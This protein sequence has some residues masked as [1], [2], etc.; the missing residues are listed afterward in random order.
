MSHLVLQTLYV[1]VVCWQSCF[2]L[3]MRTWKAGKSLYV[4]SKEHFICVSLTLTR[5]YRTIA[6][7]TNV[8]RKCVIGVSSSRHTSPLVIGCINTDSF[9]TDMYT[10]QIQ[11]YKYNL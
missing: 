1:G 9:I 4:V 5:N 8:N 3:R 7:M 2:A 6:L 10:I 11:F